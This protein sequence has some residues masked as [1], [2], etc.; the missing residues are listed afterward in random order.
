[1]QTFKINKIEK[2]TAYTEFKPYELLQ[3][4]VRRLAQRE[5]DKV[6]GSNTFKTKDD[7]NLKIKPA[8]VT[9]AQTKKSVLTTLRKQ[10]Q[11]FFEDYAKKNDCSTIIS[12]TVSF[13]VQTQLKNHLKKTYPIV[14]CQIKA[15]IKQ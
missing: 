6:E 10:T 8:F 15:L 7:N 2:D 9:K 1:M 13:R 11:S 4:A 5:K 14:N 3:T 12:D